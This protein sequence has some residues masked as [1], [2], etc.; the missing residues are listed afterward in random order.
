M[1]NIVLLNHLLLLKYNKTGLGLGQPYFWKSKSLKKCKIFINIKLLMAYL[2]NTRFPTLF[3]Y[4][5][6]LFST[7]ENLC[8]RVW[9]LSVKC[10]MYCRSLSVWRDFLGSYKLRLTTYN[11]WWLRGELK[12]DILSLSSPL[13]LKMSSLSSRNENLWH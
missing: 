7:N 10:R 1:K 4:Q 3:F 13:K 2:F 5:C 8:T 9:R 12:L 11:D 6:D